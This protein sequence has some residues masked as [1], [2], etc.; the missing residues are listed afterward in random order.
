MFKIR[1][2][3]GKCLGLELRIPRKFTCFFKVG[4]RKLRCAFGKHRY[5]I[6][7]KRVGTKGRATSDNEE[8]GEKIFS[9]RGRGFHC[10]PQGGCNLHI[11]HKTNRRARIAPRPSLMKVRSNGLDIAVQSAGKKSPARST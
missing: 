7:S 5:D 4:I 1:K 10:S 11:G 9:K 2:P 3:Q 6:Y 8:H